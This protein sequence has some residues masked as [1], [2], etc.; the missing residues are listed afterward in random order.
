MLDDVTRRR[1]GV[2]VF[3]SPGLEVGESHCCSGCPGPGPPATGELRRPARGGSAPG[4]VRV[5][6]WLYGHALREA[7]RTAAAVCA[8]EIFQEERTRSSSSPRVDTVA[9]APP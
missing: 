9:A 2:H 6:T 5:L 7:S 4:R 3:R 1:S 8:D